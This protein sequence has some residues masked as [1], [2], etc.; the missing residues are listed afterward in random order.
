MDIYDD[1]TV[2]RIM[3]TILNVDSLQVIDVSKLSNFL[4]FHRG[5]SKIIIENRDKI[6]RLYPKYTRDEDKTK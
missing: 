2:I 4:K 5:L 1:G 3:N 6:Q